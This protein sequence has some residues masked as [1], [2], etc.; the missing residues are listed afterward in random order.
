MSDAEFVEACDTVFAPSFANITGLIAKVWLRD[1]ANNAYGGVYA[2]ENIEAMERY[3][4][5]EL[6][7]SVINS[8]NFVNLSSHDYEVLE[9]PTRATN[10]FFPVG[11]A[12]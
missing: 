11:V 4:T 8:P 1:V 12:R 2:W 9:G 10:G 5:T 3:K 7:A 6:F